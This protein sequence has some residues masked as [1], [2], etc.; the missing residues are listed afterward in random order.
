MKKNFVL[1]TLLLSLALH[2]AARPA[3]RQKIDFNFDWNFSLT[4][5]QKYILTPFDK[6][7]SESVQL[8]HD[9]NVKQD[10]DSKWGGATAYLP[11]GIGWY[12]K[13]FILPA[14]TSGR[15]VSIVFDGIF[16]QSDIYINGH[17][18]GH[19]PYG[20]CS[21]VYDLTPYL[22]APGELNFMAVRVNT[23]GGRP[24]WYAG[25]GIY[26]HAWLDVTEDV[27][28]DTYGTYITTPQVSAEAA[29]VAVVTT[30]KNSSPKKQYVT[31]LQKVKD[32]TG[33]VLAKSKSQRV[34]V[35]AG[36]AFDVKQLLDLAQPKLWT[37]E[38]PALYTL[39]TSVK[40]GGS[41]TDVYT[42][43]FGI[44][45]IAFDPN[46]G[47]L[48]NGKQVKLKGMCL[49]HDAGA[50]GVAVPLRSYERRL[51]I[52]KE[53]GVNA[54]RMSHNQP[55]TEFLDLCD[56]MGFLVID[57]AFD[58]WKSGDNY[59]TR[60]F[61]EWWQKDLG[62][63]ILRD[64][65][66]PCII[67]WSIGNEVGEAWREG[68]EYVKRAAM[69]QDFVHRLEP[70]RK[71]TLAAQNNHKEAFAG[72]TDVIGYNYLEARAISDHKKFPNRCFLISEELPYYRGA[73]GNLRSYT[74]LNPW[75]LIAENDFFAG[76][77]I[78]PGVD[79]LGEAGWPSKGWPNGLF[80]VCMYEKP[81]AAYHRAMWN[82][83]PMVRIAVKDPFADIDHGRD[84]WQ[85]PAIV[86]HWN[87]PNK[88]N[89]LVIEVL[90]TTNCEEV[91]LYRN[92]KLMGRERTAD[93]TNNTIVWNIPYTPGKLE[94]KGFN[95]GKEVAYWKIETAGK[96]ATL[97]LKAD[98]QT[99]KADGQDLSHIDLT[100]IDDKGVKV[101]TD[102]RMITVKVS[103]EGR[104][105]ALDSGDLRL[106]KFYTNQIK[107]YFGH[108]LL[109]VQSTRKPGVIHAEIQVEGIDKPFEVVIRT[110]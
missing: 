28:V 44:R 61:D 29:Q 94:A 73:E 65:N 35:E 46:R 5:S 75:S 8:P 30:V 64:R 20:F 25:A 37:P 110:R 31:L 81:R 10:F 26:R 76:G 95:K 90:T 14:S 39:E 45:A 22:K 11:E 38:S 66:H 54:L 23:T 32:A 19:R 33:K 100:L 27:H 103:G 4:D 85:W 24:R 42:S 97:K 60:H 6:S 96:L 15:Q 7:H 72:V 52:L 41:T 83:T 92:G 17:H 82:K 51:E 9:W 109:T 71:V 56:R 69:L 91:E 74:P 47:F 67:L 106:N 87:Y 79:Y 50:M 36:K 108:A 102:N 98:R 78:W 55:S 59:Y 93:Y 77:F 58:K 84:L 99:I 48:L 101:Q 1:I 2:L 13:E 70:S 16:M 68:E 63:M 89:G 80:D 43:T 105:V 88:F 53:Y 40:A 21:I 34:V 107:S 104:L 57:E 12:Q 3:T 62:N 86:D 18:L 49:H